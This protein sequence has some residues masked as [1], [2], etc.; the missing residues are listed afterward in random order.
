MVSHPSD[1]GFL[2]LNGSVFAE[3]G[4]HPGNVGGSTFGPVWRQGS[5][6]SEGSRARPGGPDTPPVMAWL[7]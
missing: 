4:F 1:V 3:D 2:E 5:E 7:T 6:N